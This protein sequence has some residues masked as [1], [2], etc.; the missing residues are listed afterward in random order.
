MLALE[1]HAYVNPEVPSEGSSGSFGS[2]E[3]ADIVLNASGMYPVLSIAV[4][5][6]A[7]YVSPEFGPAFAA[8]AL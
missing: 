1:D 8:S 5:G 6:F 3:P 7:A 4:F 2:G